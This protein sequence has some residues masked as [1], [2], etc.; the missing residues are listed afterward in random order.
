MIIENGIKIQNIYYMLAY[1]FS[2]LKNDGYEKLASEHFEN[3]A[4]LLSAILAKGIAIQVKRGLGKE[5]IPITETL[6]TLRGKI[7]ISQSIKGQTMLKKQLICSYDE[8]SANTKLNQ[9]LKTTVSIL[10]RTKIKP[11]V[12]KDL[13]NLMMYFKDIDTLNPYTIDWNMRFNRNN[14][15]YQMLISICYLV[16]KGLLQKDDKGDMKMQ[17]FLDEQR[18]SRLYEKFILEYYKK[19]L[20]S[21]KYIV[22]SKEIEWNE[23]NN[24]FDFL[25]KMQSDIYIENKITGEILIIDAKFYTRNMATSQFGN[26]QTFHSNNLYQIFTYVKN[27]DRDNT[28]NV[29]GILLY[30]KTDEEVTPNAEFMMGGNKIEV[31]SLDLGGEFDDIQHKLNNILHKEFT[32]CKNTIYL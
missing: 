21:D 7:D 14:Q 2:I 22:K 23:D 15:S 24:F 9:I 12:K 29:S 30:A 25:P 17:K 13:K 3:T 26:K 6:S 5:Y 27:K 19:H 8:F 4:Y 10:L 1:A 20:P 32:L 31:R 16:I 18:M 11:Q 28:G